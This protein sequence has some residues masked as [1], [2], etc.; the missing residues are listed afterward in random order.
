MASHSVTHSSRLRFL[1]RTTPEQAYP[2]VG[3]S[4]DHRPGLLPQLAWDS[5]PYWQRR[6]LQW[7]QVVGLLTLSGAATAL[8]LYCMSKLA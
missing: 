8:W 7:K 3:A 6:R 2:E 5:L 1:A 4:P